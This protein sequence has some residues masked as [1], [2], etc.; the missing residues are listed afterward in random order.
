[1]DRW[2]PKG[3]RVDIRG[4][5]EQ[6]IN[7]FF[8]CSGSKQY[9]YVGYF[10]KEECLQSGRQR[11][12]IVDF[13]LWCVNTLEDNFTELFV[14]ADEEAWDDKPVQVTNCPLRR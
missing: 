9:R 6:F 12:N 10:T 11:Q 8:I 2:A 13:L 14:I 3:L 4:E 7:I 5:D 1:M